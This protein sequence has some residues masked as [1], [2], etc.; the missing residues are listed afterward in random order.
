M[1]TDL[2]SLSPNQMDDRVLIGPSLSHRQVSAGASTMEL[3]NQLLQ[4]FL[5]QLLGLPEELLIFDE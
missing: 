1:W 5:A 3:S 4:N 2:P